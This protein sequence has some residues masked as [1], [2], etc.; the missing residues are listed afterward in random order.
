MLVLGVGGAGGN[1]VNNLILSM[2]QQ[3]ERST[4]GPAI[5]AGA[6]PC[7]G[8]RFLAANT[9]A[10]A[11]S[12]SRADRT[13][14][15]GERL[16]G[17]LGAGANPAVGREAARACLP[18]IMEEI[19]SAHILFLT[20]G[21]GGGTGTGAAPIIAQ[22]ARA[23]GVL[24]IAVVSTPFAFEGL[25]RMRLAQA[26]LEALEPH[27]D[28]LV[29]IPNQNLFRLATSRTTLQ[30]AFRLADDVLSMTIRS[31]TDLMG[32]SGLINLDFADLDSITRNAGRAVFGVGEAMGCPA[33]AT[34]PESSASARTEASTSSSS[35]RIDRG[36]RAIESA[37]NN[38]L[39]DGISLKKA[40]GALISVSGGRDLML[41]EV[42][43][44]ASFIRDH[45]GE[46]ANIIFGST[47]DE[48]LT[49]SVRVSV[50]VTAGRLEPLSQTSTLKRPFFGA[51]FSNASTEDA[52]LAP[53]AADLDEKTPARAS[54]QAKRGPRFGTAPSQR[55]AGPELHRRTDTSGHST[56][57]VYAEK[58]LSRQVDDRDAFWRPR[59]PTQ[60]HA[61]TTNSA[62][63]PRARDAASTAPATWQLFPMNLPTAWKPRI[64][65][66]L[67]NH[68]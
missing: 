46:H 52:G 59:V 20:A 30:N 13:F 11:L 37:L 56:K 68:W 44:I 15:L 49:G 38:P 50:I 28:T 8:L 9:D 31:V 48:S 21:L 16:T 55:I 62:A 61:S 58:P 63:R 7:P 14:C 17:G 51:W 64:I 60:S 42:N 67:K 1:T 43:E 41:N 6:A 3:S 12:L 65:E 32:T 26:G 18:L 45:I 40:R 24:T 39:L 47:Y 34:E 36:R 54:D 5:D 23:A 29:M 57:S 66:F 27:V 33:L 4:A 22:A 2:R 25:H 10:Q 53:L 19:K 35:V